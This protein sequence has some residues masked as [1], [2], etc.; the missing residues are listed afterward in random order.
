MSCCSVWF[1]GCL[2]SVSW[3]LFLWSTRS[4][5]TG[6]CSVLQLLPCSQRT[7]MSSESRSQL[8]RRPVPTLLPQ[9]A[10]VTR[11]CVCPGQSWAL[12]PGW[13]CREQPAA[14]QTPQ[15]QEPH[16]GHRDPARAEGDPPA[17]PRVELHAAI[18]PGRLGC[19]YSVELGGSVWP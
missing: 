2:C 5:S 16:T 17:A 7:G 4:C 19:N 12:Q 1:W 10:R 15:P 6:A 14:T 3:Q 18:C 9:P 8:Q 13:V 11:N